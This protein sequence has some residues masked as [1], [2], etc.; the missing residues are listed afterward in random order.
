MNLNVNSAAIPIRKRRECLTHGSGNTTRKGSSLYKRIGL[1]ES[2]VPQRPLSW[3]QLQTDLFHL[4]LALGF[5]R[6]VGL[7]PMG[8]FF[9]ASTLSLNAATVIRVTANWL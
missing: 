4:C 7:C 5:R 1:T 8:R 9:D 6:W 3:T 2:V